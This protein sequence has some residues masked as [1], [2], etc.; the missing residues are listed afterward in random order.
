MV[1]LVSH[2]YTYVS[3]HLSCNSLDATVK[4]VEDVEAPDD[5]EDDD[6]DDDDDSGDDDDDE[7]Q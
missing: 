5:D 3:K 6:D 7:E 4:E 2:T 1:W